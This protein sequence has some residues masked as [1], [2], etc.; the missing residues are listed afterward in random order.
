MHF[1]TV[2]NGQCLTSEI[3]LNNALHHIYLFLQH[4][5]E[6]IMKVENSIKTY[7]YSSRPTELFEGSAKKNQNPHFNTNLPYF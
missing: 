4:P 3:T 5:D 1:K 2:M 6:R 7:S